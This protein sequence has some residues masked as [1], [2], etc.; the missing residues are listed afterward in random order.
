MRKTVQLNL[1]LF[2]ILIC[3]Q[4]NFA[5]ENRLELFLK[6][7]INIPNMDDINK[8]YQKDLIG[9]D[10]VTY[11]F[12]FSSGFALNIMSNFSMKLGLNYLLHAQSPPTELIEADGDTVDANIKYRIKGYNP[13]L[14]FSYNNSLNSTYRYSLGVNLVYSF[15]S[16]SDDLDEADTFFDYLKGNGLGYVFEASVQRPLGE[17]LDI[18]LELGY[19]LLNIKK[20][21]INSK[22]YPDQTED[23]EFNING[24]PIDLDFSGP[25]VRFMVVYKI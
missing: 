2:L 4:P 11:A 15:A 21:K 3:V 25:L 9:Y 13:F 18:G 20:L 12:D 7:G 14:G 19:R 22:K 5:Q 6:G 10:D 24:G 8:I 23:I 16:L 17:K 1:F